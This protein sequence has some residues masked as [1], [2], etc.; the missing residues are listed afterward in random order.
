MR[1][2]TTGGFD[3]RNADPYDKKWRLKHSLMLQDVRRL[4]EAQV[5]QAAHDHW[6]AYASHSN[7]EK[8]SWTKVKTQ[9]TNALKLLQTSILPWRPQSEPDDKKDTME[10]KY[11]DLIKKYKDM[12]ANKQQDNAKEPSKE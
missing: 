9:A 2:A 1:A 11:G 8:E 4:A 12:L 10:E 6:L 5:C 3:Y 7:L